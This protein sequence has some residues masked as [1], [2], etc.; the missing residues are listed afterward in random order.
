MSE[1]VTP[2]PNVTPEADTTVPA[3]ESPID[4]S[5]VSTIDPTVAVADPP[6]SSTGGH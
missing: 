1:D 5:S 4:E 2:E 3:E 6:A